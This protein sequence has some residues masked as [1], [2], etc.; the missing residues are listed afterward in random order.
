MK[1]V[2][3]LDRLHNQ[4][5][6]RAVRGTLATHRFNYFA[7]FGGFNFSKN[8]QLG[9]KYIYVASFLISLKCNSGAYNGRVG[10]LGVTDCVRSSLVVQPKFIGCTFME[11]A[12]EA[13]HFR[14]KTT[15]S[16]T[17]SH[18]NS[19]FS[20]RDSIPF[21]PRGG[22]SDWYLLKKSL[23]HRSFGRRTYTLN[24]GLKNFVL[25][26]MIFYP[27]IGNLK[28]FKNLLFTT[29]G[30]VSTGSSGECNSLRPI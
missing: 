25:N 19:F 12:H 23:N 22:V 11:K 7:H 16:P 13:Q 20:M 21:A 15:P 6:L 30:G 29:S 24:F 14:A 2:K 26:T 9:L 17:I 4:S 3:F 10:G 8:K 1:R 18:I 5:R 27:H 28:I